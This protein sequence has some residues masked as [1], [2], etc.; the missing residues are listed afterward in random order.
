ML[1]ST[2]LSATLFS[3]VREIALNSRGDQSHRRPSY[4]RRNNKYQRTRLMADAHRLTMLLTR[5]TLVTQCCGFPF[6][7]ILYEP[8]PRQHH[9]V[10]A[11][12]ALTSKR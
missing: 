7:F 4:W 8:E 3:R 12:L 9:R 10:T 1:S 5:V 6:L 2:N 11:S